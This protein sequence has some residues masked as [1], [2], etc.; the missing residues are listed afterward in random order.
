MNSGDYYEGPIYRKQTAIDVRFCALREGEGRNR[1]NVLHIFSTSYFFSS[2]GITGSI[3]SLIE[4][5]GGVFRIPEV[6]V[7]ILVPEAEDANW[8]SLYCSVCPRKI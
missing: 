3:L 6:L 5:H 1:R 8:F 7:S 4:R 2:C